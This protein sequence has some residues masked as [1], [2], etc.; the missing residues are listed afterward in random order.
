[1]YV[2]RR[3]DVHGNVDC[4][5]PISRLAAELIGRGRRYNVSF[6]VPVDVPVVQVVVAASG[7]QRARRVFVRTTIIV[8][9]F[10]FQPL[11]CFALRL[12]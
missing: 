5:L 6:V 1:M 3:R 9:L 10:V 2:R 11:N 8:R 4:Y 7:R 12:T